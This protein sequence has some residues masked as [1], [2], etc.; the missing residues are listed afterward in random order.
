VCGEEG[1]ALLGRGC[2]GMSV[3]SPR[4][5]VQHITSSYMATAPM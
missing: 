4:H 1:R 2:G 5:T 3:K